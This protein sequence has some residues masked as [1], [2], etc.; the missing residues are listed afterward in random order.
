MIQNLTKIFYFQIVKFLT[1][2]LN[3]YERGY[4]KFPIRTEFMSAIFVES[5]QSPIWET[6]HL[7]VKDVKTRRKF[8]KFV[9]PTLLSYSSRS[10][11]LW[12]LYLEC[13]FCEIHDSYMKPICLIFKVLRFL[14]TYEGFVTFA[15][16]GKLWDRARRAA[17]C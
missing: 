10:S 2:P 12:T 16:Y 17:A 9:C 14:K 4:S 8:R 1:V 6:I 11:S 5:S 7:N 3:F 13:K 15:N